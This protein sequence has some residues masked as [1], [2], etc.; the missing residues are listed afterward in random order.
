MYI[1]QILIHRLVH[2]SFIGKALIKS[3]MYILVITDLHSTAIFVLFVYTNR[4]RCDV[5]EI[6]RRS[7][8]KNQE[9]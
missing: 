2:T 9:E 5:F 8:G 3:D 7:L 1:L 4:Y 6:R